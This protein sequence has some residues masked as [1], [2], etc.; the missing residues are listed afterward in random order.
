MASNISA[1]ILAGG[2]NTRLNGLIKSNMI[3]G[4]RS[5]LSRMVEVIGDLFEEIIIVTN[6]PEE[7]KEFSNFKI[8]SDV[9]KKKGPLGGI[10]A[11]LRATSAEAL[12]VFAGDMP[13]LDRKLIMKQINLYEIS[14]CD[15]LLPCV[16]GSIEPLHAIYKS[17]V[18]NTLENYLIND[19]NC[20]VRDF[21]KMVS[22]TCMELEDSEETKNAFTNINLPSDV[23]AVEK[24]QS[25]G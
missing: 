15:V 19:N 13:L 23:I 17:S 16:K 11:A 7:F 20:A 5:I 6:T 9:Y 1:V 22:V 14:A 2:A 24:K 21:F 8:V 12:F 18:L 25:S 10:H 4:G 3:I